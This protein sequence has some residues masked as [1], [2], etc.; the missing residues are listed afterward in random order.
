MSHPAWEAERDRTSVLSGGDS[1]QR[2]GQN[3]LQDNAQAVLG[4]VTG[5]VHFHRAASDN[6]PQKC[7]DAVFLT[8][9]VSDR[10]G[11]LSTR[12]KRSPQTCEWITRDA[13]EYKAWMASPS[14]DLLWVT[15]LPGK[16]TVILLA[17]YVYKLI[18]AYDA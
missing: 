4:N 13:D 12:G 18:F 3:I 10:N 5:S 8:D 2:W 16:G 15:G 11:I 9:P 17:C 14:S 6:L 7:L 1:S